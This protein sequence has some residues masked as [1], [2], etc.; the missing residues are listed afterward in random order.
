[1]SIAVST[2]IQPSRLLLILIGGMSV[3]LLGI[4]VLV[5]TGFIGNLSLLARI[6][7][8]GICACFAIAAFL[9]ARSRKTKYVLHIS[10]IGQ[11]RLVTE[12]RNERIIVDGAAEGE[13]VHLLPVSTIWSGLLLLH[14]QNERQKITVVTILSD[15][16]SVE[17]FRA[18]LVACRWIVLRH[19]DKKESDIRH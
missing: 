15:T 10:G 3:I 5:A 6:V 19:A 1:M 17:S 16:V 7:L 9:R 12:K 14:L 8:A 18:L 13:I 2:V 11:I 4:A